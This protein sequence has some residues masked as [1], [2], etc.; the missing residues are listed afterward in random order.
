MNQKESPKSKEPLWGQRK[1][2]TKEKSGW[3]AHKYT[4]G[5]CVLRDQELVRGVCVT[6]P[7]L[8][9]HVVDA[10][11]ALFTEDGAVRVRGDVD[12]EQAR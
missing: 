7:R 4:G 5:R 10:I 3:D 12:C 2:T 11:A 6:D 9:Q 8:I 1:A